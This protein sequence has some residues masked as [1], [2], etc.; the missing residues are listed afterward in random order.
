MALAKTGQNISIFPFLSYIFIDAYPETGEDICYMK[1]ILAAV[2]VM[3]FLWSCDLL[4]ISPVDYIRKKPEQ[5]YGGDPLPGNFLP[6]P[7]P[8]SPPLRLADLAVV[9]NNFEYRALEGDSAGV[10][11]IVVPPPS[12]GEF[13]ANLVIS[14][15]AGET[16]TGVKVN[17]A[18]AAPGGSPAHHVECL[19]IPAR[20]AT[21]RSDTRVGIAIQKADGSGIVSQGR[22][23]WAVPV[24]SHADPVLKSVELS[25]I[26]ADGTSLGKDYF[27]IENISGLSSWETSP[28]IGGI[29]PSFTGSLRGNGKTISIISF[30]T[31][32]TDSAM[33][34]FART[35]GARIEDLTIEYNN[36]M[37]I[38][39]STVINAGLLAAEAENSFFDRITIL[40]SLK[41]EN[42]G[43]I[44][45]GGLAGSAAGTEISNVRSSVTIEAKNSSTTQSVYMGGLVGN[46]KG[47]SRISY[48][49]AEGNVTLT[50][51]SG[52]NAVQ[53]FFVGA[54]IGIAD[55]AGIQYSYG[56]GNVTFNKSGGN[57]YV[58]AGGLAGRVQN[59][60]TIS[61]SY[62][63][64]DVV[65][66]ASVARGTALAYGGIGG[67]AGSIAG[68]NTG[69]TIV[70]RC[71]AA[72]TIGGSISGNPYLGGIVGTAAGAALQS[73]AALNPSLPNP[74]GDK[75]RVVGDMTGSTPIQN[76][77]LATMTIGGTT[78]S[79]SGPSER[80]G[81]STPLSSLQTRTPYEKALPA[82]LGWDFSAA[83]AWKMPNT[84]GYPLLKWQN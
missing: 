26:K 8:S 30:S 6:A 78:V 59:G 20:S 64:G 82:G 7:G 61:D 36:P 49:G 54:I 32:G 2:P 67:L 17:D 46:A 60:G 68:S 62:A 1:K 83:G 22:I 38:T 33:G 48:S 79:S 40:G 9:E 43:G 37:A 57:A 27:L 77:A 81:L 42:T 44:S 3:V 21:Y 41:I 47:G 11:T 50:H 71:Y 80:D 70:E 56:R 25:D 5:A 58:H 75:H 66:N 23:V 13:S 34:L 74:G 14:A 12:Q 69:A 31:P 55:N 39:T 51:D 16:I 53:V 65:I 29:D 72:G 18:A 24:S 84:P 52:L 10:F 73:N 15:G 4:N 63:E 76:F 28:P 35:N 19:N 45:L